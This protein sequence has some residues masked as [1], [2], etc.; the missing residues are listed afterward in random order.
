MPEVPSAP[1]SA[2][3]ASGPTA[4]AL[5]FRSVFAEHVG[6][7][8]RMLRTLGTRESAVPDAAQEVFLIVHQKLASFDGSCRLSTWICGITWRVAAN[9]RRKAARDRATTELD[10]ARLRGDGD[11]ESALAAQ[12]AARVVQAFCDALSEGMRDVFVLAL[13]EERS[14]PEVADLLE[15]PLNTVYSRVR[16]LRQEL[17]GLLSPSPDLASAPALPILRRPKESS[18]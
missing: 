6:M 12:Q 9:Q 11:P 16:L 13:L 4:G 8:W 18:P 5:D 1:P 14:A 3:E 2:R 17:R 10:E 7:V 15:I